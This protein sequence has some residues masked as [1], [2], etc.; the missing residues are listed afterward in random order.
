[1]ACLL[2]IRSGD[3][4]VVPNDVG[5]EFHSVDTL[6]QRFGDSR[7]RMMSVRDMAPDQRK[8]NMLELSST[9]V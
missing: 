2:V 3:V 4:Q 1:M 9:E 7:A 8:C 6:G 5:S